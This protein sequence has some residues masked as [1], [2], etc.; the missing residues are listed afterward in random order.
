MKKA[1]LV[2]LAVLFA[3]AG[4]SSE[5]TQ[6]SSG[7]STAQTTAEVTNTSSTDAVDEVVEQY[8]QTFITHQPALATSLKLSPE[9]Y[10]EYAARLPNYSLAGMQALQIDMNKAAEQLKQLQTLPLNEDEMLHVKVNEV[11]AR[12]YAGH[13]SFQQAILILGAVTCLILSISCRARW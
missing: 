11:L 13:S 2:S 10:G 7:S 1:S 12:Y 3:L 6:T 8:T 9:Q 4:C 5:S